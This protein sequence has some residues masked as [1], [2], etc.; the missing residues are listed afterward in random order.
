MAAA[1]TRSPSPRLTAR[2]DSGATP[3]WPGSAPDR[4]AT[5]PT[6]TL[7]YEW[8]EDRDNGFRPAG[9]I[10]L[11]DTTLNVNGF[12]LQDYGSTYGAG[13]ANHAMTLYRHASGA[14]VFG[15]GTVQ[16]T[17]GPRRQP[18]RRGRPGWTRAMQ[19]A[20]VNLF[21]DMGVQP[22]TLSAG[23][24]TAAPSTDLTAPTSAI[25]SP[26]ADASVP[27][28]TTITVSGTASDA[29]GGTVGG[30]EV[31][32]DGGATWHRAIGRATWTYSWQTGGGRTV[33]LRSRAVDDSGNLEVPSAGRS[34]TVGSGTVTCPCSIWAPAQTPAVA[35]ENDN[36]ARRN[37]HAL[38]GRLERLHLR[39]S[40]LQER[41][42]RRA[43]RRQPVD[44]RRNAARHGALQQ[45]DG[46]RLAGGRPADTGGDYRE[47]QL[48]RV[49]S[50][51]LGLLCWRRPATSR[52][53]A[54]TTGHC[55]RC[56]TARMGR[57]AST[58]MGPQPFRTRRST[59][60][61]TGSMWSSSRRLPPD[62]TPPQV[63]TVTPSSG[64]SGVAVNTSVTATFSENVDAATVTGST[65]QLRDSANTVVPATVT[66]AAGSRTA[67]LQPSSGTELLRDL[68]GHGSRRQHRGKGHGR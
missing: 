42:E 11:S 61:T 63:A 16:W 15:A 32:I 37:R 59:A 22:L 44:G 40:L 66:Y 19:Q 43:V 14:L 18:R 41:P 62:T 5:L 13:I 21:A 53:R 45:R 3:R 4:S 2:C 64:A 49:V 17:L 51:E 7:G 36:Q 1:T 6:G 24:T 60:K 23:L 33:T 29:G 39:D 35:A 65:F 20:T 28:N 57:T 25:T 8:D 10:R 47:H 12:Y 67:T 31:S 50:H 48:R 46:E 26:A 27:A 56:G 52:R 68:H 34:V 55:T 54:S 30:V 38:P 58:D 9:L